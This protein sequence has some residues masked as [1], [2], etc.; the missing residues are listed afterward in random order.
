[1]HVVLLLCSINMH[2]AYMPSMPMPLWSYMAPH[3][4]VRL[5]NDASDRRLWCGPWS[6][7][8]RQRARMRG[9]GG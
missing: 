7:V 2:I 4:P 1:M 3:R 9:S 6:G 5:L 8:A